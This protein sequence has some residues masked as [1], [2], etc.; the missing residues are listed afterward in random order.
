M[1]KQSLHM[2]ILLWGWGIMLCTLLLTFFY[3]QM[4]ELV[5]G[6]YLYIAQPPL[7]RVGSR[8]SGVYLKNEEEYSNYLVQRITGQKDIFI[9][10]S[11]EPLKEDEFK[12]FH[13]SIIPLFQL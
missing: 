8:K 11:N 7:F 3:R 13:Y 1:P 2:R 4:P 10:G 5:E 6:G 9:N 12:S